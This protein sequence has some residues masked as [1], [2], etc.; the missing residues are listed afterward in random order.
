MT[1]DIRDGPRALPPSSGANATP[2]R[3][4]GSGSVTAV[5]DWTLL[6]LALALSLALV[7][8]IIALVLAGPGAARARHARPRPTRGSFRRDGAPERP[9]RAAIIINPTKFDDVAATRR[10]LTAASA[11]LGWS[12]PLYIETTAED[13]GTGQAREALKAGV[14]VVC[15]LGGDGT[16]RAVAVALAG[17]RTPMGLLPRGTGN[18]LA[19]NLD[20]PLDDVDRDALLRRLEREGRGERHGGGSPADAGDDAP[21]TRGIT[22]ERALQRGADGKARQSDAGVRATHRNSDPWMRSTHS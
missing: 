11:A 13:P 17:T 21:L 4:R 18:L 12:E 19:R 5:S 9:R 16:I 22:R 8:V 15:P 7:G 2:P 20:I 10:E 3:R 1:Q 14:D 6:A